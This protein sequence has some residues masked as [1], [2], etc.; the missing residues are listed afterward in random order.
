MKLDSLFH[1]PQVLP[2][3]SPVV[4]DLLGTLG[5]EGGH[6]QAL[7]QLIESDA[8]ITAHL[9]QLAN[10]A[11]FHMPQA[12]SS[13]SL[14][15]QHLGRVNVRS[16]VISI[17]LMSSFSHLNVQVA[18]QFWRHSRHMAVAARYWAAL[19]AVQLD[20]ELAHTLA[21]LYPIGRL[22]MHQRLP[23]DM[24]AL[25]RQAHPLS[26]QRAALEQGK[27]GFA[28]AD[29]AAELARRWQFP[30]LFAKV[31]ADRALVHPDFRLAA[32]VRMAAWQVCHGEQTRADA[33]PMASS[34][35]TDLAAMVPLL[36]GQC[37]DNFPPWT[38][39]CGDAEALLV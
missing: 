2:V 15:V 16:L 23:G 4:Q 21:L 9:L 7:V 27:F 17:G 5:R 3:I 32:L 29:V 22:L 13:V 31:F 11:Y 39:L 25:D 1:S 26:P 8:V 30:P 12:I 20:E 28:C 19:P 18:Q 37:G 35:P 33:D 36:P 24:A 34:W 6:T 38:E 14:A 10:S